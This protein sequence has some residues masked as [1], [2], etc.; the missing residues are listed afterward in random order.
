MK[1]LIFSCIAVACLALASCEDDN[2]LPAWPWGNGSTEEET[3]GDTATVV[4]GKPRYVWIDASANF[5]DYANSRENIAS[6]LAKVKNAGFTDIIVDVRPTI[7]DVLF[8]ST[9]ADPLTRVDAWM[10]NGSY[11]WL[12]RTETFDYLKHLRG[13]LLVPLRPWVGRYVVPRR[14]QKGVGNGD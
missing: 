11:V 4:E 12:E 8:E 10:D 7:G 9:V 13:W 3:P 5:E 14:K 2:K 6:D 1:R